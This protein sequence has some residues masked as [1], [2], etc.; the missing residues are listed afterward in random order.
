MGGPTNSG[1]VVNRI[2][3]ATRQ[4]KL[5]LW[6]AHHVA[7]RLGE[8][9]HE[10][11]LVK[12]TTTG[13]RIQNRTLAE[14]GGKGLF[15]KELETA[16]LEGRADLAVH[17]MKDVPG[18]LPDGFVLSAILARE[19]PR[20][21]VVSSDARMLADL[22]AGARIGSSSLRRRYQVRAL[23]PA[24]E[25]LDIR[26]NVDTR[27][28]KMRSGE[29]EAVIL[30]AA[31]LKR[32]G[33]EAEITEYLPAATCTPA[34]GQGAVGIECHEDN[35]ELRAMIAALDD[36]LTA[37][38]VRAER[39]FAR[40]LGAECNQPVGAFAVEDAS[41]MIELQGFVADP[42]GARHIR[43]TAQGPVD[44]VADQLADEFMGAGAQALLSQ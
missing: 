6:Q 13:D 39:A 1:P 34:A 41:G 8:L 31:G 40:R 18:E 23:H 24:F 29:Y 33:L 36:R 37:R 25:Y 4:S 43:R 22:D 5:A 15:I 44:A 35:A 3:I 28:G 27:L 10:V 17:S 2:R 30:A 38:C 21:V 20:D 9:G 14:I 32:L 26:G 42:A 19:D 16:M 11:T 12:V 7:D